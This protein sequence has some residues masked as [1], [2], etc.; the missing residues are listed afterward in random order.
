MG[1]LKMAEITRMRNI[2]TLIT[3]VGVQISSIITS[4]LP[5]IGQ[6]L[7]HYPRLS[8]SFCVFS[9]PKIYLYGF[10]MQSSITRAVVCCAAPWVRRNIFIVEL[11]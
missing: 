10:Y 7:P 11:V 8:M 6:I 1:L 2:L 4:P 9:I 3:S 5:Q